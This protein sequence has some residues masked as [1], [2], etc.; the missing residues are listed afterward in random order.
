MRNLVNAIAR[1]QHRFRKV[2]KGPIGSMIQLKDYKWATAV[3][4]AIPKWLFSAFITDNVYD[5]EILKQIMGQVLRDGYKPDTLSGEF[6]VRAF[7]CIMMSQV[8][9]NWSKLRLWGR[10]VSMLG[11]PRLND[12]VDV[13]VSRKATVF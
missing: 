4:Q 3:E 12:N 2:P 5:D 11:S 6:E 7:C 13:L 10:L 8:G 9:N 1:N